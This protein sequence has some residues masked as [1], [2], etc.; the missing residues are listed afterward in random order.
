MRLRLGHSPDADDAFM[1]Y[2]LATGRVTAPGLEFEHVL[3]DIETLNDW[4]RAGRLE[5]T[6]VS[7]HAYPYVAD[8]YLLTACGAS[9]GEG[10]GPVVVAREPVTLADLAGRPVA[11]PGRLTSAALALALYLPDHRPVP[12]PFDRIPAAVAAG[13]VAAG[14][15]IHE[16][17]L[18]YR[19]LGLHLV[20]D[21]GERW[22]AETGLPLPL[23]LNAVRRDVGR[24]VAARVS[25]ALRASIAYALEHREEALAYALGFARGLDP[26]R[27][28]R[29][30]AMYVNARTLDL[31][32]DGREA[33]RLFLERGHARGLVPAVPAL[34]FV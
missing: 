7:A 17:Q 20:A 32:D 6:A 11:I 28:D 24:E 9:M 29:F 26:A 21:L 3:R 25:S 1:F 22:R 4:A 30:V 2:A 10:Y 19:E 12:V 15:L 23:G 8:R 33:V 13:E 14:L 31:G 5:V 16:G 27:A 34:E 18:T